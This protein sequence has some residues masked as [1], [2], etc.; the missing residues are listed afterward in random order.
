MMD[1]EGIITGEDGKITENSIWSYDEIRWDEFV[2]MRYIVEYASND[3]DD[4]ERYLADQGFEDDY[5][6]VMERHIEHT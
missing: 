3:F 5:A 2:V 6:Y 1:F 4:I